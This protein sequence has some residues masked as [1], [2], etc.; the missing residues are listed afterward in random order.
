MYKLYF[1]N[2]ANSNKKYKLDSD[3][4]IVTDEPDETTTSS[5][6]F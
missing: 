2:I 1:I 4:N 3:A 5:A 6:L